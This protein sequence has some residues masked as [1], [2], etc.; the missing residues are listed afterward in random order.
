MVKTL[1]VDATYEIAKRSH[2]WLK[3][4]KDYLD[5]VG[6]TLDVVVMGGY[7]GK[8]KRT[9]SYGGFLLACY[10]SE[11]EEYQSLCKIGTG[12]SDEDLQKHYDFFKDNVID[13]PK[14]YYAFDS[15]LKPDHWFEPVQVWEIKAA[16]LSIS[17][18]HRAAAGIVDPDKGISLRF[19]RFIRIREDK[20]PEDATS[21]Q[22]VADMY[23][24]Q[25][26]VKN[27]QKGKAGGDD[28]FDL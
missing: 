28:D 22:Q 23:N 11:N 19:P 15:S 1:D 21:A 4:K 10:D 14:S 13:K 25:E 2:N 27:N 17:P 26:V 6:D 3:L 18:V 24:S 20:Q 5:G 16:D 7:L 8:G 12:F 9:G